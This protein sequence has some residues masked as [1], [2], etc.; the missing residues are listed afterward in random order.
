MSASVGSIHSADNVDRLQQQTTALRRQE[1]LL[2]GKNSE[3]QHTLLDVEAKLEGM[4]EQSRQRANVVSRPRTPSQWPG[5]WQPTP[6]RQNNLF[7]P[8]NDTVMPHRLLISIHLIVHGAL[9][10]VLV[11]SGRV[12]SAL[13]KA[14]HPLFDWLRNC[15][16]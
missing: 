7:L 15:V 10:V 2:E 8:I 4:K 12:A 9:S 5:D 6:R 13:L 14:D 16:T 11:R 1:R 3:L